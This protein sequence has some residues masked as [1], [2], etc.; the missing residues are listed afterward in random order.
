MDTMDL[1]DKAVKYLIRYGYM[2]HDNQDTDN[3]LAEKIKAAILKFQANFGLK[4]SGLLDEATAEFMKRPRCSVEDK[5]RSE[6]DVL[7]YKHISMWRKNVLTW[8]IT[9]YPDTNLTQIECKETM[10]KAMQFW[11]AAADIQF[12]ESDKAEN[13]DIEIREAFNSEQKKSCYLEIIPV[14]VRASG[15]PLPHPTL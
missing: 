6:E 11:A 14:N 2:L 15:K 9:K 5:A 4:E 1:E 7:D 12:E 8:K 10:R 3:H 13:C